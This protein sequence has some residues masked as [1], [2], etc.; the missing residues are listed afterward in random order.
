MSREKLN[1]NFKFFTVKIYYILK[2]FKGLQ[3]S[4]KDEPIDT[5]IFN[6]NYF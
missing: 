4:N 1:Q 5:A 2:H 3:N 6:H